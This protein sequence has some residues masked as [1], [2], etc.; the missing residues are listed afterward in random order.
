MTIKDYVEIAAA[1]RGLETVQAKFNSG[2]QSDTGEVN[3]VGK[4]MLI[5]AFGKLL[6]ADNPNFDSARF[7]DACYG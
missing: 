1:I 3:A 4:P 5:Q 7:V 2:M 6:Q